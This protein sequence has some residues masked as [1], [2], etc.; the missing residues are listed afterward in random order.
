MSHPAT[1]QVGIVMGSESDWPTLIVSAPQTAF[2]RRISGRG[3]ML[4]LEAPGQ[5]CFVVL[6]GGG[7]GQVLEDVT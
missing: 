1:P 5:E 4:G 7:V 6:D 2:L 3:Q